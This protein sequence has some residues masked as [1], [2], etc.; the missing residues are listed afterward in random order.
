MQLTTTILGEIELYCV[1][2]EE[3]AIVY[4][5][6]QQY[7]KYN[8]RLEKGSIVF[9]VGANIGLFSLWLHQ[10]YSDLQVY[11]FEPIPILF[12]ALEKNVQQ[13]NPDHFKA[14]PFGL[15]HE[16]ATVTFAYHPYATAMSTGYP[17]TSEERTKLQAAILRN[18]PEEAQ[19]QFQPML[20]TFFV[21]EPVEC[22]LRTASDVIR[23]QNIA[24]IDL[25]KI[26]VEKAEL[27]VL[28]GFAPEDW[29]KVQ[30]V[31]IE[32]HD[33]ENRVNTV[34]SLLS[35]VGFQ[36]I[37]IEQEEGMKGSNIYNLYTFR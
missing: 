10:H 25:L 2:P 3:A 35:Q 21:N 18:L 34:R 13:F 1:N 20:N 19:A 11:A 32:I 12:E 7:F 22:Q 30:Q 28:Q 4:N 6:V 37:E 29:A 27:D 15:G 14:F 16:N 5:Q 24:R 23:E 31:V 17:Y 26:D 36:T 33:V 9:D 8:I